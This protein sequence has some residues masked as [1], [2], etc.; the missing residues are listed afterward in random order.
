MIHRNVARR[1]AFGLF[2]VGQKD[3]NYKRYRE[4]LESFTKLVFGNERIYK[5]IMYPLF[6][7]NFRKEIVSDVARGLNLS[8]AVSNLLLL[9]LENNRIRY[10]S[11]IL[12][13][14]TKIVD[15]KDG[16]VRGKL[17][18]AFPLEDGIF[19]EIIDILKE[20]IKKEIVLTVIEDKSLI[21]GIK[22]V[23]NGWVLDGTIRKQL[24]SMK[25]TL[26]K[27]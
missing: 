4:E 11:A 7:L 15:E 2:G 14:Y 17:Y 18:T 25:E 20:K 23:L 9:L 3:G 24:D 16:I 27:E 10:L 26:L 22:L 21:A 6:D 12:E 19:T 5:A 1:Y 13:E 8:S